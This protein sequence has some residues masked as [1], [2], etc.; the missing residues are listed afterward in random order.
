MKTR[1]GFVSNSSS[2]SFVIKRDYLSDDQIRR[3]ENHIEE[4]GRIGIYTSQDEAWRIDSDYDVSGYTGMDNFDMGEF[5]RRIG[6]CTDCQVQW[7]TETWESY[8]RDICSRCDQK[9]NNLG[10]SV[11]VLLDKSLS[12]VCKYDLED[13]KQKI[14]REMGRRAEDD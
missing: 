2:S 3:I 4:A 5:L 6:V 11:K 7:G 14:E 9:E 8:N 10:H 13:L 12:D 1:H